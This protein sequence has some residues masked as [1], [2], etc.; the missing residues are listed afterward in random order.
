LAEQT[1]KRIELT[2]NIQE[3]LIGGFVLKMDDMLFDASLKNQ[4]S[5][6][7]NHLSQ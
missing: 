5:K 6:I 4:L 1:D 3:D 2:Q 7:K